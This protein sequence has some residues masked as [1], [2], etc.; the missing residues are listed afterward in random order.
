MVVNGRKISGSAQTRR[1]G[2]VLQHGTVIVDTDLETM[3]QVIRQRPGK[4]RSEAD[5][6]SLSLELGRKVDM[7]EVKT[8]LVAGFEGT[9]GVTM[10]KENLTAEERELA[11][12]LSEEKYGKGVFTFQ[13]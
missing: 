12:K 10:R 1:A 4:P 2:A 13:R 11:R 6:T 7:D 9:F 5:M 3:M 8:A